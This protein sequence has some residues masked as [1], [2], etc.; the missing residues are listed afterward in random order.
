MLRTVFFVKKLAP[1]KFTFKRSQYS[2]AEPPLFWAASASGGQGPGAD[3]GSDLLGLALA[4]A[5]G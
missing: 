5:P 1:A 3:S 4:P 2:V